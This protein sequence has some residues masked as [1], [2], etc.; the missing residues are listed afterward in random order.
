MSREVKIVGVNGQI[1]LG[2]EHAGR[3]V[4]VEEL[5]TGVWMIRTAQVIPDNERWLHTAPVRESLDRALAISAKTERSESDL[6]ILT[7]KVRRSK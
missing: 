2:K 3:T 6:E 4:M 5:E 7:R 1:S